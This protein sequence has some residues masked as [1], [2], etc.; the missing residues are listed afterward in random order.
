MPMLSVSVGT[1]TSSPN[2]EP[3]CIEYSNLHNA[4]DLDTFDDLTDAISLLL[5]RNNAKH[6]VTTYTLN[7]NYI[8]EQYDRVIYAIAG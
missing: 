4:G 3:Y 2:G 6:R 8:G 1:S 5:D 7:P